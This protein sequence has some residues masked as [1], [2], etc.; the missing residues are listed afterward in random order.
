MAAPSR[1]DFIPGVLYDVS[2]QDPKARVEAY[3]DAY[4]TTA[5]DGG[6]V[7]DQPFSP[8]SLTN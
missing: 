6:P 1:P 7:S 8:S 5:G 2:I 3:V 4:K